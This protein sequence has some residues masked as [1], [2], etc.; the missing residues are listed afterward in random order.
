[1]GMLTMIITEILVS[2]ITLCKLDWYQGF[3]IFNFIFFS[4][5]SFFSLLILFSIRCIGLNMLINQL[6]YTQKHT[7]KDTYQPKSLV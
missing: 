3:L 6:A 4:V 1:M 5:W 7:Q 2:Q